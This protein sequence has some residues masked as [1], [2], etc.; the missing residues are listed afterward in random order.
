[1]FHYY[2]FWIF[3]AIN[4][5][6]P[7]NIALRPSLFPS[8]QKNDI[9]KWTS[10]ALSEEGNVLNL[11][12]NTKRICF[13][14]DFVQCLMF[15]NRL[16]FV[17]SNCANDNIGWNFNFVQPNVTKLFLSAQNKRWLVSAKLET[18]K[19]KKNIKPL[20]R[21]S[22]SLLTPSRSLGRNLLGFPTRRR[23]GFPK[24]N[25]TYDPV[26]GR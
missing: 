26:S 10:K 24:V 15:K 25:D 5:K 20:G 6:N 1:M 4:L 16:I 12:S 22:A 7:K 19:T 8:P 9:F 18:S 17:R 21:I 2:N 11:I 3:A 13:E 14:S 23:N